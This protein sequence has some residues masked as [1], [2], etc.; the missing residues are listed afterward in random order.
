MRTCANCHKSM[1]RKYKKLCIWCE[2]QQR[3]SKRDEKA[4]KSLTEYYKQELDKK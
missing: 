1:K 2:K 4:F 3:D